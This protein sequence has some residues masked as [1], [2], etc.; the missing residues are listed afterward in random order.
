MRREEYSSEEAHWPGQRER[1]S[2]AALERLEE[3]QEIPE[4]RVIE[5]E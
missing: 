2:P 3:N 5:V 1:V 4:R